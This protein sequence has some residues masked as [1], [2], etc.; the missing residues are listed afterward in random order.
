MAER[1]H[2]TVGEGVI[3][4]LIGGLVVAVW[5]LVFDA[6]AGRPFWTM[7]V[8]GK[9]LFRGDV[10]PGPRDLVSGVVAG[11]AVVHL[12]LYAIIGVALTFVTHLAFRNPSLRMGLWFAFVIATLLTAGLTF[13]LTVSTADR[14]PAW[15]SVGGGLIGVAA[16]AFYLMRRH[17]RLRSSLERVPLGDEVDPS[18]HPS[19]STSPRRR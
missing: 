19:A 3:V 6:A 1:E 16:M 13:M 11:Y 17:P 14:L 5:Y 8:L 7:N 2:S 12:I 15:E 9:I 4:G 10:N 18:A